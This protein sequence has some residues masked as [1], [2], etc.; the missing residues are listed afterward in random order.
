MDIGTLLLGLALSLGV[1]VYILQ[2]LFEPRA[3]EQAPDL[4]EKLYSER[5]QILSA[6]HDLDFDHATGKLAA[7]DYQP[8]RAQLVARGVE[9]LQQLD[10]LPIASK[11]EAIEAAISARRKVTAPTVACG[12][13]G[14]P[15]QTDAHFCA[16]CGQPLTAVSGVSK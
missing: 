8:Q 5:E 14:R 12:N 16:G 11:S 7:A 10:A 15:A 3:A 1:A 6:L 9:L 2:P 13:C 4:T